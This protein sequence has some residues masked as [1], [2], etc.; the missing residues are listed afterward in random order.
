MFHYPRAN[1][2]EPDQIV[3]LAD[4]LDLPVD[5]IIDT[6]EALDSLQRTPNT[7]QN[8]PSHATAGGVLQSSTLPAANP[9]YSAFQ[10]F[11]GVA[12]PSNVSCH[13]Y[14]PS[15]P[16]RANE[17][18][19]DI[20]AQEINLEAL[21]DL[22]VLNDRE[23]SAQEVT[24]FA[25]HQDLQSFLTRNKLL[26]FSFPS[27]V[28]GREGMD[29]GGANDLSWI[30]TIGSSTPNFDHASLEQLVMTGPCSRDWN[31]RLPRLVRDPRA[32][33]MND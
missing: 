26:N 3:K 22:Y 5:K 13:S 4:K 18:Q 15:K 11:A 29:D 31:K 33:R 10:S 7:D 23:H 24:A 9:G 8:L 6:I 28:E 19:N 20:L 30:N 2:L 27:H 32:C 12:P 25:A 21:D 1:F 14:A 17:T 16:A